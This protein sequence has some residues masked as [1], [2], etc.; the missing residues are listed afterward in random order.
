[1][2]GAALPFLLITVDAE[3]DNL[4]SRP[5]DVTTRNAQCLPPFQDLCERHGC[6]PTYLLTYE[7]AR[8]AVF[9]EFG[10]RVVDAH[11]AEIGMHLHAWNSPP[12]VPLTDRDWWYQPHL[13]HYPEEAM[14]QKIRRLTLT[15]QDAFGIP[16]ISHRGGRWGFD[17]RYA[18]L[19][20][21][22]GYKVDSS[23]TPGVSWRQK[24]GS[25]F[26]RLAPDYS[27]FPLLPYFAD[28]EDVSRPGDSTLL[29]V[30]VTTR[31][32]PLEAPPART[33]GALL[34]PTVVR[35][36]RPN[37]RNGRALRQLAV[38]SLAEGRNCLVLMLHSSE[39]LAGGSPASPREE[40]VHALSRDVEALLTELDGRITPVTMSELYD[41]FV[42]MPREDHSTWST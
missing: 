31:R 29:E 38:Q 1:M 19:L 16:V 7:M 22:Q 13:T 10:R 6:R 5:A 24:A 41:A 9:R 2:T 14:R 35:W 28:L 17:E 15:I 40:D 42:Q 36:L 32:V 20:V 25:R 27:A 34:N 8:C 12:E 4:W 18:R 21:E 26:D 11:A 39:L 3:G 33:D 37:G 23:V 30:P